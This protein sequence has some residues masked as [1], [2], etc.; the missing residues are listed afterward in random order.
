MI[1]ELQV[2]WPLSSFLTVGCHVRKKEGWSCRSGTVWAKEQFRLAPG[3]FIP[4]AFFQWCW[5]YWSLRY[6]EM[7]DPGPDFAS[8]ML[9]PL[10][11][12]NGPGSMLTR[13]QAV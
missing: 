12:G 5:H 6:V 2:R 8:D 9:F 4:G 11:D 13:Q 10:G 7:E 1:V 3:P